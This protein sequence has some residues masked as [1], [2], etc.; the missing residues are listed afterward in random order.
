[1]LSSHCSQSA[2][3]GG[4]RNRSRSTVLS[5]ALADGRVFE[6]ITPRVLHPALLVIVEA[7]VG[8]LPRDVHR[9]QAILR[10]QDVLGQSRRLLIDKFFRKAQIRGEMAPKPAAF[11]LLKGTTIPVAPCGA[12]RWYPS[13]SNSFCLASPPKMGCWSSIRTCPPG[14]FLRYAQQADN[15][16]MP[17][18][19]I[20][21][22]GASPVSTAAAQSFIKCLIAYAAVCGIDDFVG[23]AIRARIVADAAR[24]GPFRAKAGHRR[25]HGLRNRGS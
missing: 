13:T 20:T 16:A 17:Q 14:R 22:S 7:G 5:C 4:V 10:H 8:A 12:V 6:A 23:V 2:R 11:A 19:T 15:P 21:T 3:R 25:R 24:P 18:P 9:A 1:M